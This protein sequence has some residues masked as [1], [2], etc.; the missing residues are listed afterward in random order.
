MSEIYT[1]EMYNIVYSEDYTFGT[2]TAYIHNAA[3]VHIQTY[4]GF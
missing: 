2:K 4:T 1:N 3:D